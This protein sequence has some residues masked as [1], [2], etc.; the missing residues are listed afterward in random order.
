MDGA[1]NEFSF[2]DNNSNNSNSAGPT[3]NIIRHRNIPSSSSTSGSSIKMNNSDSNNRS[4]NH[5]AIND[6]N[7][8]FHLTLWNT[9]AWIIKLPFIFVIK[10]LNT[11]YSFFTSMFYPTLSMFINSSTLFFNKYNYIFR[12]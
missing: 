2:M 8:G 6:D 10:A 7:Q 1:Y 4:N 9:T 5:T 11:I 12:I 3:D